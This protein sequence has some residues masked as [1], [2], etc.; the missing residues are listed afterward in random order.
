ML[1]ISCDAPLISTDLSG[2]VTLIKNRYS[3]S[4]KG[5]SPKDP[6]ALFRSL[7]LMT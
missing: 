1:T 3:K 5:V 6:I 2:I 7:I 4:S